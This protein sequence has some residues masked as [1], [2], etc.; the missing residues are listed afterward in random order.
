MLIGVW[1]SDGKF[2]S[3]DKEFE[4]KIGDTGDT[5]VEYINMLQNKY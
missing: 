4:H 1:I 5:V 3:G 2:N